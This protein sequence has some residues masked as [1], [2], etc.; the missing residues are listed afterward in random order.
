MLINGKEWNPKGKTVLLYS[1]GMDSWLI[2]KIAKPDIKLFFDIGTASCKGERARL[3]SD[4]IIDETLIGLGKL[5]DQG[6]FIVPLRN[7]Y[8]IAR[9]AE[10]G[11]HIIL[12]TNKTD[13]HNDKL[14]PFADK[15]QDIL[16]YYYG[17]SL[18][19]FCE[20]RDIVVDFSYKQYNRAELCKLYLDMGGTVEEA[21][22]TSFS[23]YTPKIN[24]T[25]V[26]ECHQCRPCFRKMMGFFVNGCKFPV[27]YL[28]SF[29]KYVVDFLGKCWLEHDWKDR[30]YTC[31]QYYQLLDAIK[32]DEERLLNN[33]ENVG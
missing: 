22:N 33:H 4:V 31:K 9:A 2:D 18:D 24:N 30:Y 17:P 11:D 15:M 29:K 28:A 21:I 23:C 19:G 25:N 5:E 3:S 1:G 27:G 32:E 14:Q 26:I 6:N 20:N 12:G 8:F 16:N 13:I 7:M 10:Y